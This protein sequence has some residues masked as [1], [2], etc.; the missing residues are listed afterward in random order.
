MYLTSLFLEN[1]KAIVDT[2]LHL[3][4]IFV[5]VAS[6]LSINLAKYFNLASSLSS[7]GLTSNVIAFTPA[8][9]ISFIG[10]LVSEILQS[11]HTSCK[12]IVA[13][14]LSSLI[15]KDIACLAIVNG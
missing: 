6:L 4:N 1:I 9:T 5:I 10:I 12:S 3:S 7:P 11:S 8:L 15:P 13:I 14:M 2:L